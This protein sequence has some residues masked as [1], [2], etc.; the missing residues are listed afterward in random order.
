MQEGIII[1]DLMPEGR[2]AGMVAEEQER[3]SLRLSESEKLTHFG[4]D[5]DFLY[6]A[7]E[8]T[9]PAAV[10]N[11]VE[12]VQVL[13][14]EPVVWEEGDRLAC[15]NLF[16]PE[17]GDLLFLGMLLRTPDGRPHRLRQS[18]GLLIQKRRC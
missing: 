11:S 16:D 14:D 9:D 5:E 17:S 3:T 12:R 15:L 10:R 7:S 18:R 6:F 4:E 8:V 13:R 1:Q 2:Y